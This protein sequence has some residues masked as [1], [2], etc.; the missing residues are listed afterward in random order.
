MDTSRTYAQDFTN[1]NR[2]NSFAPIRF[3]TSAQWFI[4][5]ANHFE[6]VSEALESAK[7]EIFIADWWLSPEIYMRR[8]VRTIL[9][10]KFKLKPVF[11][12]ILLIFVEVIHGDH[13]RLDKILQR[14]ATQGVRVYI[15]LYKEVEIG[16]S[17]NSLYSKQKLMKM[18]PNIKVLR[19]PDTVRG[20]TLLWSH[21]E[22]LVVI[23]QSYAFVG[24][25]D[26]CYG[27][28]DN[29]EHKLTDLGGIALDTTDSSNNK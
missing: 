24:G 15:L 4:D 9:K 6:A 1:Y 11:H 2:Y 5:G 14:K 22:K 29:F 26:L 10:P 27:R 21:H 17:I 20:G 18:H 12:L 28:W 19:H 13:W 23:D 25:I 7:Q 3:H 8:P 16:I